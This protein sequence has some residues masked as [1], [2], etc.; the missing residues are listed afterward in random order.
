MNGKDRPQ[1]RRKSRPRV[2]SCGV[3]LFRRADAGRLEF[4]L[5][6]HPRRLD[7]PKGRMDPGETELQCALREMEE[8]TGIPRSAVRLDDAFRFE[9]VYYPRLKRFGGVKVE[10]TLVMF[11]GWLETEHPV[12]VTEHHDHAWVPWN[13][14]HDLQAETI[15]P[16]LAAVAAHFE[17]PA[18]QVDGAPDGAADGA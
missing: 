12:T 11:L 10:K 15:N 8:E 6:K 18:L 14:P 13:P 5:M 3:I 9:E 7:L 2:K 17:S 16:L 4:L 1:K